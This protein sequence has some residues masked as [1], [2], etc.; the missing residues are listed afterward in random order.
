M[1]CRCT[2][3]GKAHLSHIMGFPPN[4]S[5]EGSDIQGIA[6]YPVFPNEQFGPGN[7]IMR[8]VV[9]ER[10]LIKEG[11]GGNQTGGAIA[12]HCVYAN[13]RSFAESPI[14]GS[15]TITIT[16]TPHD[17]TSTVQRAHHGPGRMHHD[18]TRLGS[19]SAAATGLS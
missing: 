13:T 2:P 5:Q 14:A 19:P 16:V 11:G 12:Y 6:V 4:A 9:F 10:C 15:P 17:A 3:T 8:E 18:W 7:L 1:R